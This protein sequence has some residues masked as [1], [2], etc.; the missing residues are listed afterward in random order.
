MPNKGAAKEK[1]TE[2]FHLLPQEGSDVR[3]Y[4]LKLNRDV[5]EALRESGGARCKVVFGG[6]DG[7][8]I[9]V[10]RRRPNPRSV[11]CA[12]LCSAWRADQ[13]VAGRWG[14]AEKDH[15]INISVKSHGRTPPLPETPS[16]DPTG[17]RYGVEARHTQP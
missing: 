12:A 3:I 10:R 13:N 2:V 8:H 5:F 17:E 9:S 6:K 7:A 14:F 16:F 15:R 1:D 11:F 4:H